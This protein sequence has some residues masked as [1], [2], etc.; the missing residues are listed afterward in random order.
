MCPHQHRINFLKT[1]V[2]RKLG[3]Y[4]VVVKGGLLSY[5]FFPAGSTDATA[6]AGDI[7]VYTGPGAG[8]DGGS[9][10]QMRLPIAPNTIGT[11]ALQDG[12]VT[13]AKL[14]QQSAIV[15]QPNGSNVD[16]TSD[17]MNAVL[18]GPKANGSW[19]MA[20]IQ[21]G[22]FFIQTYSAGIWQ[23]CSMFE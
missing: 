17:S 8:T 21:D 16:M 10:S 5:P 20:A 3:D 19:R 12:T 14:A 22:P 1:I 13:S 4:F 2:G 11:G 18:F 7:Y 15:I 9:W 6:V 23:T